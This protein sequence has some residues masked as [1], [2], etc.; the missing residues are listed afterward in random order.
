[1]LVSHSF[2]SSSGPNCY[3]SFLPFSMWGRVWQEQDTSK[4]LVGSSALVIKRLSDQALTVNGRKPWKAL[5]WQTM[6]MSLQKIHQ[7]H[8]LFWYKAQTQ[9]CHLRSVLCRHLC[10]SWTHRCDPLSYPRTIIPTLLMSAYHKAMGHR[11]PEVGEEPICRQWAP[12][13]KTQV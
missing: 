2:E 11:S 5:H 3:H 13:S 10:G 8:V 7:S 6:L 4:A 9:Q 12:T 1:M